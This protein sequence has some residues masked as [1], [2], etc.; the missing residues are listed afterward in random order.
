MPSR[1]MR[2]TAI[3]A[4]FISLL[5]SAFSQASTSTAKSIE[6]SHNGIPSSL[7][8]LRKYPS[9]TPRKK[10]FLNVVVP[11]IDQHNQQIMQERKWLLKHQDAKH[12]SSQDIKHLQQICK[13]Y[14]M[15][16]SSSPKKVNWNKL[17]NRVDIIPTHFVATQAATES[18]W[19]TSKLAQQNNNLFGMRCG[20]G[21]KRTQGKIKG[22]FSYP[23][24]NDSVKAYMRNMNT[25]NAYESLRVSRAKQR[26][27]QK[28]LNTS[29][30]ID[31]LE[32]YS[33]LGSTYN[34]YLHK[35][36]N[37]NKGLITQAQKLAKNEYD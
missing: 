14:N 26:S 22:Y 37:S 16:C 9:G 6:Y 18:G 19:G 25:H 35:V 12:W 7:P 23:T 30:L 21:C 4:F 11:V 3:F 24:I 36:F 31:N 34:S 10:A 13:N 2:T 33:Q 15:S 32:G 29:K 1:T 17:L 27:L 8:D 28:S 5:F 20:N